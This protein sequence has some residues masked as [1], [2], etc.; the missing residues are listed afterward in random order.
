MAG[1][2]EDQ[3]G[4]FDWRQSYV[5]KVNQLGFHTTS[6]T[7]VLV[8]VTESNV[9]AGLDADSGTILWRHVFESDELGKI[10]DLRVTHWAILLSVLVV[11]TS[12][13]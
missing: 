8:V 13:L 6:V 2:F 4:K 11:L 7:S 12:Y 10:W 9:V 5:G 1:L 3:A